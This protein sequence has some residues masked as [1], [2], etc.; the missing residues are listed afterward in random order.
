MVKSAT[1]DYIIFI[2]LFE[3]VC[4]KCFGQ[5][6]KKVLSE[7]ECKQ[8]SY[9]IEEKT[10]LVI[11]RKS[12]KNYSVS[13][14]SANNGKKVIN[15]TSVTL[16]TLSRYVSDAPVTTE[17]QL[18]DSDDPY[19]Y[20]FIYRGQFLE[21]HE[22]TG[23]KRNYLG[24]KFVRFSIMV[25]LIFILALLVFRKKENLEIE[26]SFHLLDDKSLSDRGWFVLSKE[27]EYWDKWDKILDQLTLFTL[28]GDNWPTKELGPKVDNVLCRKTHKGNFSAEVHFFD[29]VPME[30]QQQAGLLLMEDTLYNGKYIRLTLA[31]NNNLMGITRPG[32][33]FVQVVASNGEGNIAVEEVVN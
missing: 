23:K 17:S 27:K 14:F 4:N 9:K 22:G 1:T 26:E 13:V 8:L 3:D 25:F 30:N 28:K 32:K 15:P 2:A 10:G 19:T 18:K 31:Y 16:D 21:K 5:R 6:L 33:I 11:G 29:F 12:Q 7:S 24:K 20:W